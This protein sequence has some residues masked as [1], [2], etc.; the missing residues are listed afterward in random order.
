MLM[1]SFMLVGNTEAATVAMKAVH[2]F[3][4]VHAWNRGFLKFKEVIEAKS[5]KSLELTIYNKGVL[6]SEKDYIQD[7]MEGTMDLSAVSLSSA[8]TLAPEMNFLDIPFIFDD[9]DH[10]LRA[11]DG[12]AGKS[13]AE[14]FERVTGRGDKPGVRILGYWAGTNYR[15]VL[16][17]KRC[18]ST[19]SELAGMKLRLRESAAQIEMWKLLGVIPSVVAYQ[20]TYNAIQTGVVDGLENE[21]VH[22]FNMKF[23]EVAPYVTMTGHAISVV[24]FI[25]SGQ[26]WKKLTHQQQQIVV[27]AAAEA[28]EVARRLEHEQDEEAANLMRTKFGVQFC[29]FNE[30]QQMIEKT[31][32]V[33]QRIAT[34]LHMTDVFNLIEAAKKR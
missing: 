34:E 10:W 9:P 16:S 25:M 28:T 2:Y 32:T 23:Y 26:T 8:G 29:P 33:R 1:V 3:D 31:K 14:I 27:E 4:D 20:E 30:R 21:M 11:M 12:P 7:L 19:L 6:G 22:A 15:H 13:F 24:P 17:R 5:N 18:Y